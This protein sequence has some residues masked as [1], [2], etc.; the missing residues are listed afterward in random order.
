MPH[1]SVLVFRHST[2]RAVFCKLRAMMGTTIITRDAVGGGGTAPTKVATG[3]GAVIA[4]ITTDVA[5]GTTAAVTVTVTG[6]IT[7]DG[8]CV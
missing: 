1:Q 5:A 6:A 2:K 7:T 4:G 8:F 3:A